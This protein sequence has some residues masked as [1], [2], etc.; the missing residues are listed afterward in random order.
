MFLIDRENADRYL[1]QTGRIG[2]D[3][4]VVVGELAGGVSNVVLYV[5]RPGGNEEDFVLKQAR[6]Q[7]RVAQPWFCAV[8]R[9][10]RELDVLRVCESILAADQRTGDD[11]IVARMPRVLFEDRDNFAF[12]MT[13]A[14]PDHMV[15]K[16]PLLDGKA[17]GEIAQACGTL[18]GRIHAGS[19]LAESVAERLGDQSVFDALRIDPYYRRLAEVCADLAGPLGRLIESLDVH[20]RCLVHADFSPKNLLVYTQYK[21]TALMMVDFETGHYGDPAFDLGFFLSHLL[22]KAFYHAPR[23]EPF[24]LLADRFWAAY[25]VQLTSRIDAV[26]FDQLVGRGLQNMAGCILARLD[27]KS[28]V[29]YL[30]DHPSRENIRNTGRELFSNENLSW[31]QARAICQK[32]IER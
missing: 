7:L 9:N 21:K 16:R 2:P 29:D 25:K 22:L 23:H 3:E 18:L 12:A 19:W 13:A 31:Q 6:R 11:E 8:E 24:L 28:P 20:R 4:P 15:W 27:G 10:W 26:E 17:D 30:D 32:G 1:R 14:P 5:Q